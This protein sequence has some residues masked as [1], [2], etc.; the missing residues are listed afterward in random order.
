MLMFFLLGCVFCFFFRRFG[1]D[2]FRFILFSLDKT[3]GV[4]G[5]WVT[6][7]CFRVGNFSIPLLGVSKAKG[8]MSIHG[9]QWSTILRC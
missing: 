2:V 5:F 9:H 1:R 7:G 6:A 3:Q 4:L 8:S